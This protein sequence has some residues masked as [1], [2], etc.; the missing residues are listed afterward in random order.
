MTCDDFRIALNGFHNVHYQSFVTGK[1]PCLSP[2]GQQ[3]YGAQ[4]GAIRAF[5]DY[6]AYQ[7]RA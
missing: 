2:E 6:A 5:R 7:S 1:S 4:C 3:D